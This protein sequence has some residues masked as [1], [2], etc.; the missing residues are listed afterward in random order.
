MLEAR[1]VQGSML[2]R[3]F[4]AIREMVSDVNLDC[5]ESGINMQSMDS[6][7]VALVSFKLTD[8]LFDSYRCD[9]NRTLGLNINNVCKVFKAC[10][11]NDSVV[12]RCED[13]GDSIQFIFE[14]D[15]EEKM[16]HM[17]LK[18]MQI[19]QEALG[20][21]ESEFDCVVL[22]PSK[23]LAA[24]A[25]FYSEFS[26]SL[27]LSIDKNDVR[28]TCKGDIGGGSTVY[29]PVEG[30]SK[31]DS[32]VIKSCKRSTTMLFGLRYITNFSKGMTLNNRV[33]LSLTDQ[34]PL[35][36]RFLLSADNDERGGY[37]RFFL[38]PKMEDRDDDAMD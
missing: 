13:E 9:M 1:L 19:D 28:F 38:A 3:L 37:L 25:K 21:P 12:M 11:V 29:K 34:H 22:M 35:E 15:K 20:V 32:V 5:D 18:L 31:E 24:S 16:S 36:V 30:D 26:D 7:H 4:E 10:G 27:T 17:E 6:S 23:E 33:Q 14:N 2:K 8:A